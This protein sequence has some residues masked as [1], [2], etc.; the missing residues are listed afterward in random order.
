ASPAPSASTAPSAPEAPRATTDATS[1]TDPSARPDPGASAGTGASADPGAPTDADAADVDYCGDDF[2]LAQ[3]GTSGWSWEGTPAEQLRQSAPSATFA[4][5]DLI[6]GLDVRC[7]VSYRHPTDGE[8]GYAD[9]SVA[10]VRDGAAAEA[11]LEQWVAANGWDEGGEH[12]L[13]RADGTYDVKLWWRV[14]PDEPPM[15]ADEA[16]VAAGAEVGDA[17]I[18]VLDWR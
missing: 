9:A 13:V 14:I 18:T 17:V 15:G 12:G 16:A 11:Q 4:P 10:V 8:R 2:V 5:A 3:F 1:G 7:G 6:D